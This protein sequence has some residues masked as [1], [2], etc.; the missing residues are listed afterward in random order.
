M[1]AN[2]AKGDFIL[3]VEDNEDDIFLMFRALKELKITNKII[4]AGDGVE[5]LATIGL[6]Q[7]VQG[8]QRGLPCLILLDLKLP[9]LS[10]QEILQRL[11]AH[12]Q[13]QEIPVIAVST[14]KEELE[15]LA[16]RNLNIVDYIPKSFN[17]EAFIKSLS[18]I[19]NYCS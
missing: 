13:T 8:S 5:A 7:S 15:M 1:E 18:V 4:V 16:K 11:R 3:L 12:A 17:H 9:G 6:T 14:S 2:N 19:K 10:G